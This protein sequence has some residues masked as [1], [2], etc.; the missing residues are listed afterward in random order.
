MLF[1]AWDSVV[2]IATHYGM[3]GPG[4]ETWWWRNVPNL[5]RRALGSTQPPIQW[6]SGHFLGGKAAGA[7]R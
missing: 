7:W 2:G 4:I 5:S 6:V 1:A 3:D